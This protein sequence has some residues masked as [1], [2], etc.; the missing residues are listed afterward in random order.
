MLCIGIA[1]QAIAHG[2]RNDEKDFPSGL[3]EGVIYNAAGTIPVRPMIVT[4]YPDGQQ[5]TVFPNAADESATSGRS[6]FFFACKH[7]KPKN[8]FSCKGRAFGCF[9][10]ETGLA[11]CSERNVEVTYRCTDSACNTLTGTGS[12]ASVFIDPGTMLTVPTG[13]EVPGL[14]SFT[15][16]KV[17]P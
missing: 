11:A 8:T 9:P 1:G 6:P 4:A 13:S 15:V 3:Y 7:T 2:D 10:R 16:T 17:K 5:T 14:F 12:D